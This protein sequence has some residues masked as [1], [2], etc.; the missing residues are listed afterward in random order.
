[1]TPLSGISIKECTNLDPITDL[2]N[3]H[4]NDPFTYLADIHLFK[5]F[6]RLKSFK[7]FVAEVDGQVVGCIYAMR[8]MYDYGW[9]GGIL[10]HR[11]FRRMG[12]GRML[13]REALRFLGPRYVYLF[14]ELQNVA[15]RRLFENVGFNAVYRRLN[16]IVNVPFGESICKCDDIDYDIEWDDLTEALGFK[17]RHGIVN[18]G[19]YPIKVTRHVFEDLRNKR[20]ILKCGSII[21]IVEN[22][23]N[24]DVDGYTFTFNDYILRG[25]AISPKEKIVEVNP[26]YTRPQLPN[27]I[28]LI[29]H[30][31]A[32]GKVAVRTYQ[33]D[34]VVESLPGKGVFAAFVMEL[35]P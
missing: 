3:D 34:H 4:R 14:V 22:S 35:S 5:M 23:Y 29:N 30:L 9:I 19:Y 10:V 1:M 26:F 27:L 13:L 17:E 20:K 28:K 32:E 33:E 24:V 16:Y 2:F 15:A 6:S 7:A 12:V 21:A 31:G 8:Y 25:L 11:K 18:I